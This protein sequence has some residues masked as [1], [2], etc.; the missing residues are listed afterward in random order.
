M[1]DI[2]YTVFYLLLLF[3]ALGCTQP[4]ILLYQVTLSLVPLLMLYVEPTGRSH[5][6]SIHFDERRVY[7]LASANAVL[8]LHNPH[9]MPGGRRLPSLRP[10]GP[11]VPIIGGNIN[12][13]HAHLDQIQETEDN[14]RK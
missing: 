1:H 11:D 13:R 10:A 3:Q 6:E 8:L 12:I 7:N 9:T 5:R 2:L 14:R 4:Y